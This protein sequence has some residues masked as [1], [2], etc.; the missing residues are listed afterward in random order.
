[1][2]T[3]SPQLVVEALLRT[4]MDA[5]W[6]VTTTLPA[7]EVLDQ[8]R[9]PKDN[10]GGKQLWVTPR[11][12]GTAV[13]RPVPVRNP[14]VV[15]VVWCKPFDRRRAWGEAE[16]LAQQLIEL[17]TD[18]TSNMT[19]GMP[20][21]GYVNV[22]LSN[23][24]PTSDVRRIQN[25]PQG[26]ARVEFDAQLTYTILKPSQG[27][28]SNPTPPPSGGNG[29]LRFDEAS[30]TTWTINHGLGYYPMVQLFDASGNEIEGAITQVT[31]DVL[32]VT[33]NEATAGF[34]LV[35]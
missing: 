27:N 20:Y 16:A 6:G 4:Q 26:L 25:D 13:F 8:K 24:R 35:G 22:S 1:M 10:W 34:A 15:V 21:S 19:L 5:T 29:T 18:W 28:P 23:F 9:L 17:G 30:S 14:F 2:K 7:L 32:I 33:F 11:G 3:P 12:Y 31:D